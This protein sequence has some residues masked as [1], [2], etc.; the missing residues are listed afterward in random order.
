[1]YC[2]ER[3]R[4]RGLYREYFSSMKWN[5]ENCAIM[6]S[7]KLTC[8][9]FFFFLWNTHKDKQTNKYTEHLYIPVDIF[10]SDF[11]TSL[12]WPCAEDIFH[13]SLI[14]YATYDAYWT[15][16]SSDVTG[17]LVS[18]N[19]MA[20]CRTLDI[21]I[22]IIGKIWFESCYG[23]QH[24]QEII[25]LNYGLFLTTKSYYMASEG[26]AYSAWII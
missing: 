14:R 11:N 18:L 2:T 19:K 9:F 3:E 21:I 5:N 8:C 17:P 10:H 13:C 25:Y 23:D 12:D 24:C 1:M 15:S 7:H 4:E 20:W 26:L 22:E 6:Y 16:V